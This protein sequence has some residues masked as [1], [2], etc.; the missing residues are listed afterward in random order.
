MERKRDLVK[1]LRNPGYREVFLHPER[2]N[3][4]KQIRKLTEDLKGGNSIV[5]KYL[6]YGISTGLLP[7]MGA[8]IVGIITDTLAGISSVSVNYDY[9]VLLIRV[10]LYA[11]LYFIFN[12]IAIYIKNDL[13][14]FYFNLRNGKLMELFGK[15]ASMEYGLYEDSSFFSSLGNWSRAI[16]SNNSGYQG[17]LSR[18]LELTG[19]LLSAIMLGAL[20]STADFKIFALGLISIIVSVYIE[21]SFTLY[22]KSNMGEERD[23]SRKLQRV[24]QLNSDFQYGKDVRVFSMEAALQS[25]MKNLVALRNN[26]LEKYYKRRLLNSPLVAIA[27]SITFIYGL[28]S[29]G[30]GYLAAE[31]GLD[32]LMMLITALLLFVNS[33]GMTSGDIS[34]IKSEAIYLDDFYDLL[35]AE[36]EPSGGLSF[37]EGMKYDVRFQ[38]VWFKYPGG[39]DWVLKGVSFHIPEGSSIALVGVNGAGKTSIIKLLMG[40]YQ[41][42]EGEI[43]IGGVNIKDIV[44]GELTK[45]FGVVFQDVNPISVTVAENVSVSIKDIDMDRDRVNEVLNRVGLL[46]KIESFPKGV[47]SYVLRI[48]E[49][50]GIILS[51]GE[52]QKLMMA[53]ALYKKDTKL[54]IMDEPTAAL[55]A[56]AEEEIYRSFKEILKG[57]T[58]I[59]ISHRL[60]STR[61]CDKIV[62]LDGGVVT[63]EGTHEELLQN[64]SLYH[65]MYE[66]QAGYYREEQR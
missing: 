26:L 52:N 14:L 38:N 58:S 24:G 59:F 60:A 61:F 17:I 28:Y 43:Y 31:F 37:P 56:L 2:R 45:L 30:N 53:R 27:Y 7:I 13:E 66:T 19:N 9:R 41:P 35:E 48:V 44:Q 10:G 1:E 64:K 50:D 49:D 36:L 23:I 32:R 5:L 42:D 21:E 47:D 29:L 62:L 33:M 16:Q 57:K 20:L 11:G 12:S 25:L 51:G 34:Y 3:I 18:G 39:E 54:L 46:S 6:I 15:F 22:Q 4:F 8:F 55:D 63:E 65:K 40:L